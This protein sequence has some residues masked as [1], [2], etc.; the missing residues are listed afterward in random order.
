MGFISQKTLDDLEFNSILNSVE[1][2]CIS[3]LGKKLTQEIKPIS[4]KPDLFIELAQV[5]EYNSSLISENRI[6]NH[7]FEDLTKEIHLL[8]IDNSR[9]DAAS[10][11]KIANVTSIPR[12]A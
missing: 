10:L 12:S 1:E 11:L 7:Y 5:K 9:L 2:H 3:D 8:K 4:N 6:P